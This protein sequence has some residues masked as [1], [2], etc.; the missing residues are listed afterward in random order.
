MHLLVSLPLNVLNVYNKDCNRAVVVVVI[1]KV[2]IIWVENHISSNKCFSSLNCVESIIW[3]SHWVLYVNT[4]T[5]V[6]PIKWV[7]NY[8]IRS[9]HF[10]LAIRDCRCFVVTICH[11]VD[12]SVCLYNVK[13]IT[14]YVNREHIKIVVIVTIVSS[15]NKYTVD[16]HQV[17]YVVNW[18]VV[19]TC[20]NSENFC[21]YHSDCAIH[22]RSNVILI[23]INRIKSLINWSLSFTSSI[24]L[25]RFFLFM[26]G[27]GYVEPSHFFVG[28]PQA[29]QTP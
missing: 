25:Y 1:T 26:Y 23:I 11:D 3:I 17:H 27:Y 6:E 22:N 9:T 5:V 4:V 12:V 14:S 15:Y 20:S 10:T 21:W 8:T 19:W 29:H 24:F 28:Q 13:V 16:S 18:M 2:I 7:L